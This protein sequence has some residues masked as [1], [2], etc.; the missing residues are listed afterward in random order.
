MIAAMPSVKPSTTGHGMK[1]TA[2][3]SP[4]MPRMTTSSPAIRDTSAM[5]P[6]P[7]TA[8]TGASTT[9]IAPVGPETWTC[10]PP[11]TAATR[12]ATTAVMSPASAPTPELTPN[13]SASGRATIPTVIPASRSVFQDEP[14]PS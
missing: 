10:E 4:L 6:T 11:M 8:T 2:R 14:S 9:T 12:P 1:A 7:W 13:A 3:P 5:L